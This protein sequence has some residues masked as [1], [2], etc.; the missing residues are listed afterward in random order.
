MREKIH[1]NQSFSMKQCVSCRTWISKDA[2]RCQHCGSYQKRWR[3]NID[4]SALVLS[5]LVALISVSAITVPI[6]HD[7]FQTKNSDIKIAIEDNKGFILDTLTEKLSFDAIVTN[8]GKRPGTVI[9]THASFQVD[10]YS[11]HAEG[12][13]NVA[14]QYSVIRPGDYKMISF[15]IPL[16]STSSLNSLW[17]NGMFK[18]KNGEI[19]FIVRRYDMT[20]KTITKPFPKSQLIE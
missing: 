4:F 13:E 16:R 12:E 2:T 14:S 3:R 10:G 18:T 1:T 17:S 5:L 15:N 20:L 6:L 7:T 9:K 19:D 11:V 8:T